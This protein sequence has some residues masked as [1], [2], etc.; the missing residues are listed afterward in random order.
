MTETP[1]T[2]DGSYEPIVNTRTAQRRQES[3]DNEQEATLAVIRAAREAYRASRKRKWRVVYALLIGSIMISIL[4]LTGV[5]AMWL[6]L[7]LSV[8]LCCG[9]CYH[10]GKLRA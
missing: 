2:L 6:S 3:L 7:P 1:L 10:L 5:I 8:A 4:G 9:G